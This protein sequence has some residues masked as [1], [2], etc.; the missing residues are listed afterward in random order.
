VSIF[1]TGFAQS[2]HALFHYFDAALK[3]RVQFIRDLASRG[4]IL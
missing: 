3:L 1:S 4:E 2:I